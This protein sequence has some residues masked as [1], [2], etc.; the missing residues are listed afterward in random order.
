MYIYIYIYLYIYTKMYICTY[1]HISICTY[2]GFLAMIRLYYERS[3]F[4]S[5]D[6][7]P[8]YAYIHASTVITYHDQSSWGLGCYLQNR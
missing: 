8:L 7:I 2:A 5:S 3:L 6:R 4:Q 1:T